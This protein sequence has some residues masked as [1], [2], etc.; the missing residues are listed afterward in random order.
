MKGSRFG[1]AGC[2]VLVLAACGP[3]DP[4]PDIHDGDAV[5][6][7]PDAINLA[8]GWSRE[9]QDQA[10]FA[11]F[12]SRL[13]PY[14]WLL[15]LEQPGSTARFVD[16]AYLAALGF[17]PQRATAHNPDALP[18]GFTRVVDADGTAWAGLGCAACHT[19][20]I[21]YRGTRIRLDGGPALLD[22][23]AF[24]RALIDALSATLADPDKL[25]RFAAALGVAPERRQDLEN[26]MVALAEKLDARHRINATDVPYG[27][28][29]LDAFGQIFNAVAVEFLGIPG[30]RRAPDAPVSFPVLWSAPHLDVVQWNA[31]A[32]NAGP[33]P[34]FQNVTTALAVYG[35]AD[36]AAG[37]GLPGYASTVD[38]A[39]LGRIQDWMYELTSP[40]WPT[41]V[42]GA[43]DAA[44]VAR[45]A[46]VYRAE[47]ASCH[48]LIDRADPK[49]EIVAVR[50]PL[51]EVGTDPRMARNFLDATARTGM[52]EGRKAAVVAGEPFGATAPTIQ[53]VAHAAIG[54]L[55]R[56][57]VD[58]L[59]DAIVGH[60][61]VVKAALD[62]H[63]EYYKARPLDGVW[64]SAPYLHNGSVPSLAQLLKPPAE[65]VAEFH[66]GNREFDPAAVGLATGPG[67][68]SQRFDTRLAGNSNAGHAYGTALTAEQKLDL[69]E[70]LKTL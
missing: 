4:P 35:H 58:A 8:Q 54:T 56:H 2:V 14:D 55:L 52:L 70:Y 42:L 60:H 20:E 26:R 29:R 37:D 32:P 64:A 62:L 44:R 28:G 18:V 27:P 13:V 68:G 24:E 69:I 30:N 59:R 67:P 16:D 31:S 9:V 38:F 17:L 36:L 53:L 3:A 50:T 15:H 41:D 51:A 39:Q 48:A 10:W 25:D 33:G 47:C 57:P 45:G 61:A 5:P 22:F 46:A 6:G 12:G 63:P 49:R 21:A 43:P 34:L 19:G 1:I 23:T 11:S 66:V 40:P 65:R 7:A